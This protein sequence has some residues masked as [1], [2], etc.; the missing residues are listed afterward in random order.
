MKSTYLKIIKKNMPSSLSSILYILKM[1][2][3]KN[4]IAYLALAVVS[5]VWGT[6]YFSI[7][8]GVETFPPF[9]F[10]A[11]RQII[12]GSLLLL[13]MKIIGKLNIRK[14]IIINQLV[15]GTL[16]I[17]LGNG[18][19]GWCER[20]IP[21]G[22][23]AL[24]VSILPLYIIGLNYLAGLEQ[25]KM[26]KYIITGLSL[27]C[28]GIVLIFKDNLKD[29]VNPVYLTGTLITFGACFFWAIGSVYS[30]TIRLK[31][32]SITNAALQML[33]GGI[34][35]LAMSLIMDDYSELQIISP[36]AI[37]TLVYLI[38]IGS[39]ISYPCYVYALEKLPIGIVSLYAYINPVIALIL[40]F[41]LLNEKITYTTVIALCNVMA[42]IYCINRG[43]QNNTK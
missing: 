3:N 35:L 31:G 26:N 42:G 19:I 28:L 7:R 33:F 11:I 8:I 13:V 12:A 16:M 18:V 43:Y 6:T 23:A 24:I 5:I 34:V 17:A 9:L 21:S 40:G 41:F 4:I 22:L 10:S 1:Q 20:Y 39:V 2:T 36:E 37:W 30:K 38:L 29:F 27:G 14:S 32:N 15:L 25:Q